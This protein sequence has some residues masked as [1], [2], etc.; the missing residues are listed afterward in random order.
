VILG[1]GEQLLVEVRTDDVPAVGE[2]VSL[3]ADPDGVVL[4]PVDP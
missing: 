4:L 1:G 3:S 2:H